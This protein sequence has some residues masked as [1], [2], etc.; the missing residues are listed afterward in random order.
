MSFEFKGKSMYAI[1]NLVEI[2]YSSINNIS[3]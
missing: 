1:Y 2:D 3:P